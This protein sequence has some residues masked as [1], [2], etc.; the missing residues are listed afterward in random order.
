MASTNLTINTGFLTIPTILDANVHSN[1]AIGAGKTIHRMHVVFSQNG[2]VAAATQFEDI[3][4]GSTASVKSIYA[5]CSTAPSSYT[6]GTV[7]IKY[8]RSGSAT[9]LLSS[10]FGLTAANFAAAGTRYNIP[11]NTTP[12][13]INTADAIQFVVVAGSGGTA[14]AGLIVV[15]E[16]DVTP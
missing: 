1:A 14:L 2:N 7:D 9:S 5:M 8:M 16:I 13:T 6:G 3:I 11:L 4:N 10:A 12:T 15:V